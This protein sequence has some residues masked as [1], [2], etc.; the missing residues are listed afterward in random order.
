MRVSNESTDLIVK[1]APSIFPEPLRLK[2]GLAREK[3]L[4]SMFAV[5]LLCG[6]H[7]FVVP[8]QFNWE[9][10]NPAMKQSVGCSGYSAKD[11]IRLHLIWCPFICTEQ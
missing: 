7:H 4:E 9:I 6:Y 1:K 10:R 8:A 3:Y 2:Q 11:V 5:V